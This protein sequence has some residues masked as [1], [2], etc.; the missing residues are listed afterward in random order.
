MSFQDIKIRKV[1]RNK[2]NDIDKE[3]IIPLLKDSKLYL[4]G[5]GYF[6]LGGLASIA[7]GLI[8]YIK[9]GGN[10]KIVTSVE[11][12]TT[13]KD[14]I[15]K[16]E[17]LKEEQINKIIEAEIDKVINDENVQLSLDLITNL[18]AAS[19]LEIKIAY[20][21]SNGIYHEKIGFFQDNENNMVCFIGSTNETFNGYNRNIESAVTLASWKEDILEVQEQYD[22]FCS[23]WEGNEEDIK[24]YSFPEALSKKILKKYKKSENIDVSIRNNL[25]NKKDDKKSLYPYQKEA[26]DQFINNRYCHFYEMATGTGK[27][28]TAVKT[29]KKLS[30]LEKKK[31][32]VIIVPQKDLQ[33]Q[34]EKALIEEGLECS[35]FGGVVSNIDWTERLDDVILDYMAND[36]D[37]IIVS[38]YDTYFD[39]L[40]SELK[41]C[42]FEK[43]L[44]CDEAHELSAK[45]IS[46]LPKDYRYKLGLSAT[47]E[48]YNENETEAILK[49]FL[50]S[51]TETFMYS[52]EEAIDKGYLANYKY[53]PLFVH[54]DRDDFE[55]YGKLTKRLVVLMNKKVRDESEINEVRNNRSLILKK[56]HQ[57]VELLKKML[58]ENK[59]DFTNSVVYCG[60]GKNEVL[61]IRLIDEVTG[62]LANIGCLRVSQ[63]TSRTENRTEVLREFENKYYDTLV[64]IKC[65]DQGVDVP[66]LDKIYIMASDG[67]LKQTIQR[68]GR[69]LRQC[70][71]TGKEI[72]YIFDFVILPPEGVFEGLGV[73]GILNCELSRVKEYNRLALNKEKN[74]KEVDFF[75]SVYEMEGEDEESDEY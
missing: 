24:V 12:G 28:Y 55:K 18:I 66:M 63:F 20:L 30:E 5:T 53:F 70:K 16:G 22:Y 57:K 26:I 52:I 27:T 54:L 19:R 3:L 58:I 13:E 11:L 69:V 60:Q 49:Y 50:N 2:Y 6:S 48:R 31:M 4:R 74:Q 10:I 7:D 73:R 33:V 35:L 42:D 62:L 51:K 59:H 23:L 44:I 25:D 9:N 61:D 37:E 8:P 67:S 14:I 71:E 72:A 34:W 40:H 17:V 65:F 29:I 15:K 75:E 38:T 46:L 45:Q 21:E 39:K 47:P 68:R 32:V 56:S 1:Y 43:M 36:M 64:A 41:N